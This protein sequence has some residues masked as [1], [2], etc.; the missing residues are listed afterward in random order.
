LGGRIELEW[1]NCDRTHGD[2]CK[3]AEQGEV[4][5]GRDIVTQKYSHKGLDI[6]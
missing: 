5:H 6:L 1:P 2:P 3:E 4:F